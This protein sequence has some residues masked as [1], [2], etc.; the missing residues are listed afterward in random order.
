MKVIIDMDWKEEQAD[1]DVVYMGF[2]SIG[3][4]KCYALQRI[5]PGTTFATGE[6]RLV[7]ADS[8]RLG[9]KTWRVE[10]TPFLIHSGQVEAHTKG[11]FLPGLRASFKQV[12]DSKAAVARIEELLRDF[13]EEGVELVYSRI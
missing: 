12:N 10:G 6:R 5:P 1:G 13:E 4:W 9:K 8:A 2:L 3:D 7:W 11:C